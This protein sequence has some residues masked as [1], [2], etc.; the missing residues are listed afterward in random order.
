MSALQTYLSNHRAKPGPQPLRVNVRKRKTRRNAARIS[1]S[2]HLEKAV[3]PRMIS[4]ECWVIQ[5]AI[6]RDSSAHLVIFSRYTAKLQ[7]N[8]YAILLTQED[9]DGSVQDGL[10]SNYANLTS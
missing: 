5:Q 3:E 6:G 1:I 2:P 8:E 10:S 9:A 4:E 7:R